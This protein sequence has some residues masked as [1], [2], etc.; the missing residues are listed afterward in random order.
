MTIAPPLLSIITPAY[1]AAEYLPPLIDAVRQ[2]AQRCSLEWIVID[3]GSTDDTV[4]VIKK[5]TDATIRL[6]LIRQANVGLAETRNRGFAV[7]K[8]DFVWFVDSDDLI[9]ANVIPQLQQAM[10]E[11]VD[12]V[13]FQA[14]RFGDEGNETPIY[15]SPKPSVVIRGEKWLCNQLLQ[16]EGFHFAWIYLYRRQFLINA[17]LQFMRG[18]LHE[19]IAFTTEAMLLAEKVRYVDVAAYRYRI[20]RGSLTGS[21]DERR[22]LERAESYLQVVA[23]LRNINRRIQMQP[24]TRRL[25]D[26]EVV[27]QALQLFEVAKLMSDDAN[28]Q[29]IRRRCI[30]QRFAQSLFVEAHTFKRFRQVVTMWL[31][32]LGVLSISSR[33]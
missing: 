16:K 17:G 25:L 23:Q 29:R 11:N 32:Q 6:N 7:A 24:A 21:R 13:G 4:A 20:T 31:K 5:N 15:S 3:D 26:G 12:M 30:E 1:N 8:G 10:S 28:W 18:I 22:L 14:M 19:D 27:G 33:K 9:A 2:A